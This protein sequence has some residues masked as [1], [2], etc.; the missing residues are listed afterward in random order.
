MFINLNGFDL[1]TKQIGKIVD[2]VEI[3]LWA[4]SNPRLFTYKFLEALESPLV[5]ESLHNWIDLIFG[6]K[7]QGR[8]AEEALNLFHPNT[9]EGNVHIESIEDEEV[10]RSLI[11][12]IQNFGQTPVQIFSKPH[13]KR[14]SQKS[15]STIIDII[16]SYSS[17]EQLSSLIQKSNSNSKSQIPSLLSNLHLSR[18]QKNSQ[19]LIKIKSS[20]L[21]SS[22]GD[23]NVLKSSNKA[24]SDDYSLLNHQNVKFEIH[25]K[26][27]SL[28]KISDSPLHKPISSNH[29]SNLNPFEKKMKKKNQNENQI[30]NQNKNQNE[31]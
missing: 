3:P 5:S 26:S 18:D 4:K 27:Q 17:N 11:M 7:Q 12:E 25:T 6:Y 28:S 20:P 9:Y 10:K 2:D 8:H 14:K 21:H 22:L 30:Q 31:K 13:P 23:F 29:K 1:G 16:H 15:T 19:N 24:I